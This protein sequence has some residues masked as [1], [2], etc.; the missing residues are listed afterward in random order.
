MPTV[1]RTNQCTNPS[2]EAGITGW[3]AFGTNPPTIIQSTAQ[4]LNRTH[5]LLITWATSSSSVQGAQITWTGLTIG[6]TYAAS[7]S[8]Y[9]PTGGAG[10]I[11][12]IAGV[13]FGPA[14]STTQNS[15]NT[16]FGVIFVA[17]AT[18]HTVQLWSNGP[19]T[20]GQTTHVDAVLFEQSNVIAPYFDGASSGCQ[21]T[22]T[23][24]LSTSQQLSGSLSITT[25]VDM[26]NEPPRVAIFVT[27]AS[28]TTAQIT[29][30]DPDGAVRPVRGGD[31]A[32]L[33]GGQAI[34]YDYEMPYGATTTYTV[35]DAGGPTAFTATAPVATTQ[36]RLIHPGQPSLSIQINGINRGDRTLASGAAEHPVLGS[37]YPV[38]ITDGQRK[39]P[40]YQI[41]IRTKTSTDNAAVKAIL[42][43]CV[44]LLLQVV[45]P[46][47]ASALWRYITV[48]DATEAD[49]TRR[50]G[51]AMRV[52][53]LNVT[54]TDRP[55]GGI[56]AQRT[57]ADVIAEVGTWADLQ[58]RYTTWTGVV[59]GVP[60]T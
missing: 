2:F 57:W 42:A 58:T 45:F 14:S 10:V 47:T 29:R 11:P 53:T 38:V 31:P 1:T 44:P 59:T 55:A 21:W 34:L 4:A 56:A 15:W 50:F 12:V 30:T 51:D 17:S 22:G 35:I 27:G 28:G 41:T 16:P 40:K 3:S 26:V 36:S 24:D 8:A 20:A 52:W 7:L 49:V 23:A 33:V 48:D 13:K 5:S 6:A 18:S 37:Q 39:A 54:E 60:H 25:S 19:T 43:G 46:F 9:T 32:P